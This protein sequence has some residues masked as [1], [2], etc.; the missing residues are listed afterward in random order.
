M[1]DAGS[2]DSDHQTLKRERGFG[3]RSE[4]ITFTLAGLLSNQLPGKSYAAT[5]SLDAAASVSRGILAVATG[6]AG[7]YVLRNQALIRWPTG[8]RILSGRLFNTDDSQDIWTFVT[9]K[10]T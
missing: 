3:N 7:F 9:S 4:L 8:Q 2:T 6:R 1:G 5:P 10:P